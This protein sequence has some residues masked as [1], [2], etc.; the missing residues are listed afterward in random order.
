MQKLMQI[1]IKA[2]LM[3]KINAVE[4]AITKN[5][6]SL[7]IKQRIENNEKFIEGNVK[8]VH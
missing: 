3:T 4:W 6:T 5:V 7:P 2:S 1:P 8:P